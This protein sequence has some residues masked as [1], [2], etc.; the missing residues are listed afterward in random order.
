V[1]GV[2][3][4]L[5]TKEKLIQVWL[6]DAT[7]YK[8]K[9]IVSNKMRHYLKLNAESTTLYFKDHQ[10]S[11]KDK[12]TMKNALGYKF[13]K[14]KKESEVNEGSQRPERSEKSGSYKSN[15]NRVFNGSHE[16][17]RSNGNG[18]NQRPFRS[19]KILYQD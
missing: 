6:K 3:L 11:M 7:D 19:D 1:I 13:E 10:S 17:D 15:N 12:S 4:S 18:Y 2:S 9:S 16:G 5:R 14:K 8:I